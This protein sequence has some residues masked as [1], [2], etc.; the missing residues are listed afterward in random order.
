MTVVSSAPVA[1]VINAPTVTARKPKRSMSAAANGPVRPNRTR[2][3]ETATE[4]TAR[5]Q[6]NSFWS[7]TM[8]TL[9][10]ARKPAAPISA[11]NVTAATI[12]A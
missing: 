7:G 12:Q 4:I 5:F 2:L 3:I 10:A 11:M 9:G 8:S 6:P 1:T